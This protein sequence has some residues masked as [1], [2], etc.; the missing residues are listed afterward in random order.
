MTYIQKLSNRTHVANQKRSIYWE[1]LQR[2]LEE[3]FTKDLLTVLGHLV[4]LRFT[5]RHPELLGWKCFHTKKIAVY[6]IIHGEQFC[7]HL[8]WF[9]KDKITGNSEVTNAVSLMAWMTSCWRTR[10]K[11]NRSQN[12]NGEK[13]DEFAIWQITAAVITTNQQ[14]AACGHHRV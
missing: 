4:L 11:N 9:S 10:K 1:V 14:R 5:R 7:T 3:Q 6:I 2:L 13:K 8:Q 12:E